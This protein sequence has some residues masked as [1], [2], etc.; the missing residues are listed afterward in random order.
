[1]KVE[2]LTKQ[3]TPQSL[4]GKAEK[5][6]QAANQQAQADAAKKAKAKDKVQ[7]SGL[8]PI[9]VDTRDQDVARAQKV[10]ALKASVQSGAYQVPARAVAESM[11]TKIA[12]SGTRH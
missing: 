12:G 10:E 3:V 4:P 6:E 1:M 5:A 11:L 7:L 8:S 9:A 2:E